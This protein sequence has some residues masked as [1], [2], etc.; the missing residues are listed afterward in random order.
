MF[1]TEPD[2]INETGVKWWHDESSTRYARTPDLFGITLPKVACFRVEFPSGERSL[3]IVED[4]QAV[5]EGQRLEDMGVEIDKL[6][7]L[8]RLKSENH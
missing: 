5:W 1:K 8:I 3:V 4:G 6:K 7:F 2:F